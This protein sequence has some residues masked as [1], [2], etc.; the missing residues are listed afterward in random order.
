MLLKFRAWIGHFLVRIHIVL[1]DHIRIVN[2][3]AAA[4]QRNVRCAAA[5]RHRRDRLIDRVAVQRKGHGISG[6]RRAGNGR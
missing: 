1:V 5:D 3:V 2:A 6:Q 4:P